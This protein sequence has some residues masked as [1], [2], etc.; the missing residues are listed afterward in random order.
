MTISQTE[1]ASRK[2]RRAQAALDAIL[3]QAGDATQARA[4]LLTAQA[5]LEAAEQA[6]QEREAEAEER[7]QREAEA[8]AAA[9]AAEI[10][11]A[12]EGIIKRLDGM[13]APQIPTDWAAK[14]ARGRREVARLAAA[15]GEVRERLSRVDTR[16]SELVAERQAIIARRMAGDEHAEDGAALAL[17]DADREGLGDLS[18]RTKRELQEVEAQ[19]LAARNGL[20]SAERRW[21]TTIQD[22]WCSGLALLA[23]RAEDVI[24]DCDTLMIGPGGR[25]K[26][27]SPA[28]DMANLLHN[29]VT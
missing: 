12:R 14:L 27:W 9:V 28:R 1:Q 29:K 24:T 25:R 2:V 16:L 5:E 26:R 21:A 10:T 15:A 11:E 18:A 20:D 7:V 13:T 4:D 6:A 3:E 23:R 19:H 17:I 8:M 22:A